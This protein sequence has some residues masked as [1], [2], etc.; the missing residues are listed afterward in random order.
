MAQYDVDLRDYWRIIKKRRAIVIL[1][2]ILVSISSYGFAKFK[3]PAPL[4]EALASVKIETT[5][6]MVD[7]FSGN[8][9]K[10]TEN[11]ATQAIILTSF[12]VLERTAK[13]VGWLPKNL[14]AD[15]IR[16]NQAH[17]LIIQ[18]LKGMITAEQQP[19]TNILNIKVISGHPEK[20]ALIANAVAK[21]FRDNNIREKNK[22][23]FETKAFIENQLRYKEKDLK[24]AENALRRFKEKNEL[25]SLS[26]KTEQALKKLAE[27]EAE[28]E[29]GKREKKLILSQLQA[30]AKTK[31]PPY[32]FETAFF[33]GMEG[34]PIHGLSRKLSEL[35]L[36]RQTLLFDF[37]EHH[38]QVIEIQDKIQA[39]LKEIFNELNT[40]LKTLESSEAELSEIIARLKKESKS[41]PEKAIQMT[42]L[43]REL[44]MH[45]SLY[46]H[47]KNKYQEVLIQESG[48]IQEVTIVKPAMIPALPFNTP[49]KAT[50]IISGIIMGIILGLVFALVA[51]TM[52]TSI[53][54][55]ED[56][57]NL[58]DVS[59]LGL[60][61]SIPDEEKGTGKG[62]PETDLSRYLI[63]HYEPTSLPA[64]AFRSLR[65]NTQFLSLEKKKKSFLLT[66]SFVQ[67]GKTFS[68]INL[69]LSMAQAGDRV[70]LVDADLRKPTV[71]K[72][73]GIDRE[74]GLTDFILGNY[75]WGEVVN[76]I[77]DIM[78]GQFEID[79]ILKTQGL[80]NL[81]LITAG[82]LPLNPSE[83][84][85][86]A[87][88]REFLKEAHT[89]YDYIFIDAPP[90]LPVADATEI[91]PHVDGVI[92]V[93]KVG[94]IGRGVVK[95]AKLALDNV[96][97]QVVGVILNNIKAEIG[98]EYFKYHTQYYY[99]P[100]ERKERRFLDAIKSKILRFKI[101][102]KP[103]SRVNKYLAL[104]I[105]VV[106]LLIGIFWKNFVGL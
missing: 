102:P 20:S 47:L 73:L 17:L 33:S 28:Y 6:N 58:L 46:S 3:E 7:F 75:E 45:E 71:H 18:R 89:R 91:A 61:P 1:M 36:E 22:R 83:I 37:T 76:T 84:L 29:R 31:N 65:T 90:I 43:E 53:G 12:P 34:S 95:R 5:R 80:D 97:A 19:G 39:V 62:S 38:P 2:V 51:E 63:T 105:A 30:L 101:K 92:L 32:T 93:Y 26:S 69:A 88:F 78:L 52:D 77:T 27:A 106:L 72:T 21:A 10:D 99:K 35:L 81:S 14:S 8:F 11:I 67:E 49:S 42:R 9:W 86:S 44:K 23:T 59:V 70:L 4:Y 54:D 103:S 100:A 41:I 24:E 96:N 74:P 98:P 66:S 94:K 25:I 15:Q 57:E 50:M 64:E 87:R 68:T 48:K 85:R 82:T 55:I 60:L 104:I 40:R 56:V 13:L 79:D 16:S